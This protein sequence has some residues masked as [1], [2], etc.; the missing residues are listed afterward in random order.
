MSP[1]YAYH[2]NVGPD[3]AGAGL[4][5]LGGI[6]VFIL[7]F[8]LAIY[9]YTAICLMRMA[10]KTKTKDAWLAWIPIANIILMLNIAKKPVWWLIFFFI[11]LV[12]IAFSIIVW[13][14]IAK[15]LKKPEWLGVFVIFPL[16]NLFVY[17]YL[18]FSKNEMPAASQKPAPPAAP[19]Q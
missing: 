10:K 9:I 2:A 13:M 1:D 7:V 14:E 11:P 19:A 12:N 8:I 3:T 15:R 4:A 6:L 5:I 18:A 17:G 16:V